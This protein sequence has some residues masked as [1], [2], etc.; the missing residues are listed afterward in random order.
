MIIS[1]QKKHE[2]IVEYILYMWQIEDLIR[3]Y[4]FDLVAIEKEIISQF[5]LDQTSKEEMVQWYD[6]LI[7]LMLTENVEEK[8]HIQIL[9]NV[10]DE[11]S[12]LHLRLLESEYNKDYKKEFEELLP[13]LKDLFEKVNTKE[14]STIEIFLEA[15]YGILMLKLKNAKI[16]DQT[17]EASL[18]ISEFLSLLSKKYNLLENDEYFSI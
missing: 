16:S 11:L 7:Q 8:G 5:D 14:K 17:L 13:F 3:A 12:K 9:I 10:V 4:N 18:K 1:R 15:L 6:D 2:N